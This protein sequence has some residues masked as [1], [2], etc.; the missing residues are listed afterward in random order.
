[1]TRRS[2]AIAAAIGALV[3]LAWL[4]NHPPGPGPATSAPA[5]CPCPAVTR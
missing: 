1:M 2:L 3:G 5:L 4:L